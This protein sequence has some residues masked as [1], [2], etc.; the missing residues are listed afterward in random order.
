MA[1]LPGADAIPTQAVTAIEGAVTATPTV[2]GPGRYPL[3]VP[4]LVVPRSLSA[5]SASGPGRYTVAAGA[6]T[7]TIKLTNTGLHSGNADVYAWGY[8]DPKDGVREADLRAVGVQALPGSTGR[9]A[10]HRSA[11]RVRRQHLRPIRTDAANN[12]VDLSVDV[13]RDG[14]PDFV[15][16]AADSGLHPHRS[17]QRPDRGVR[18]GPQH[19]SP[20]RHLVGERAA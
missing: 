5:V 4:F 10:E 17:R 19:R 2:A 3:R 18:R 7:S 12:E 8:A 11:A 9:P 13:D 20:R 16:I 6:A 1:A 14:T 15:V